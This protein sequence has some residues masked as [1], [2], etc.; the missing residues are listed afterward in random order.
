MIE[1]KTGATRQSWEMVQEAIAEPTLCWMWGTEGGQRRRLQPGHHEILLGT[2]RH[3]TPPR[4]ASVPNRA[5]PT[6]TLSPRPA[7]PALCGLSG[8]PV[9]TAGG[10]SPLA[11]SPHGP[12]TASP[13]HGPVSRLA[14][15]GLGTA[16]SLQAGGDTGPEEARPLGPEPPVLWRTLSMSHHLHGTEMRD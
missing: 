8:P 4:P 12:T 14:P 15:G 5:G 13:S 6:A 7:Q 9:Y 11:L 3:R 1:I 10:Q 16:L 2:G